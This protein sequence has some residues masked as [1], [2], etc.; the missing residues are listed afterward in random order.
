[1]KRRS[2]SEIHTPQVGSCEMA[3]R[4][5]VVVKLAEEAEDELRALDE[6]VDEDVDEVG[7]A[8]D[9]TECELDVDLE[10]EWEAELEAEVEVEVEVEVAMWVASVPSNAVAN[11]S[12]PLPPA[13]VAI[14]VARAV[15][16]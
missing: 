1:M 3:V 13:V 8:V 2:G 4:V 14:V 16:L 10:A 15:A 12:V 9:E 11:T 7:M 5:E 6:D